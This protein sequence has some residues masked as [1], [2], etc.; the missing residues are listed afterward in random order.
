MN[1]LRH[2][3]DDD[4]NGDR[5]T[6]GAGTFKMILE[7]KFTRSLSPFTSQGEQAEQS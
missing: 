3:G 2:D 5:T 1:H 4:G 6:A 7:P